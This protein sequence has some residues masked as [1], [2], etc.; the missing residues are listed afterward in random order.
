MKVLVIISANDSETIWNAF[1]YATTSLVYE[2]ETTVFLLGAGVEAPTL[3][4]IKFDIREQIDIFREHGGQMLGCGV[5]CELRKD[6]MPFLESDLECELGSMQQLYMLT[7][8]A[9]KVLTF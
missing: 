1:R 7:A 5:C 6:S 3:G 9:E 4:T 2:N 8:E